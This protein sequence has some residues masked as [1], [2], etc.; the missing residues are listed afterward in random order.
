MFVKPTLELLS[1]KYYAFSS[2]N[3]SP[4]N[5]PSLLSVHKTVKCKLSLFKPYK[6]DQRPEFV[7][8]IVSFP[9]FNLAATHVDPLNY[10]PTFRL[11]E[12]NQISSRL[13]N[14]KDANALVLL[15]SSSETEKKIVED[16]ILVDAI[17]L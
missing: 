11:T 14:V 9:K 1:G 2:E 17:L 4:N 5:L 10:L 16:G 3:F 6:L 12:Q 7:R 13:I 15:M 8:G